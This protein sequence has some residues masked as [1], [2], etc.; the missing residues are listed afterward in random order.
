MI[1]LMCIAAG[2]D[3]LPSVKGFALKTSLKYVEKHRSVGALLR[4]MRLENMLPLS[5]ANN[6]NIDTS[7]VARYPTTLLTY[8]LEFFKVQTKYLLSLVEYVIWH[9]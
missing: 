6:D 9:L 3:Y 4:A 7:A 1:T 8:E 2:C 5:F